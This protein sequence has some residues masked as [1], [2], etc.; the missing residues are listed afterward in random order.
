[1]A[2]MLPVR[3]VIDYPVINIVRHCD[4]C[5]FIGRLLCLTLSKALEK[6]RA[7]T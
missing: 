1:M 3:E 7:M 6:S 5:K 4:I 2:V